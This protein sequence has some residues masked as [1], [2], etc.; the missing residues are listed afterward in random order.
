LELN[1]ALSNP[2]AAAGLRDLAPLREKLLERAEDD[3]RRPRSAPSRRLPILDTVT[4][5]LQLAGKSMTVAAVH[6]AVESLLKQPLPRKTI[7]AAL[8]AGTLGANARF[9]RVRRGI[10]E[11]NRV[12]AQ[13]LSR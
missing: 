7:K 3:P 10:Y 1:G 9:R 12:G 6:A 4:V 5:A 8:S 13:G 11:R 2:H